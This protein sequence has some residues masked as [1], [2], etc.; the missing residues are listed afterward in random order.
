MTQLLNTL[1]VT[2]PDAALHLD[3]DTVRV[4]I[5]R[6]TRT[7]LPLLHLGAIV[8]FGPVFI[9]PAL[10]AR[11]ASDGCSVVLLSRTGRF[12]AR[13]EGPTG[14][15]VL[16]RRAQ[17][18]A[19][20]DPERAR[21][22][23]R[24]CIAGKVQNSRFVLLRSARDTN[25]VATSGVLSAA[26]TTL[27]S[28]LGPIERADSTEAL[29]GHEGDA[30]R[31]YF[32]VL[33][34]MIR[35]GQAEFRFDGRTRR[36]PRDRMNALMSFLYTLLTADCRAAAEAVGLD[37]QVGFLHALRPGRPALALDLVEE[38]RPIIADRLALTLINRRQLK[39]NDFTDRP[40]GAVMLNDQGRKTALT[41]YQER[42]RQEV[43]HRFLDQKVS[44][45]LIPHVQARLLARHL[46]GDL[47]HYPP[48]LPR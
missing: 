11:C 21:E 36:P 15:N 33:N 27:G 24:S 28:L 45:G 8:C 35:A 31:M 29:R 6:E 46:R 23:A 17:H 2:T 41:A 16:L 47:G 30:A 48:F 10:I 43:T 39:P 26:A 20:A 19:S 4:E 32:G 22:I 18:D 42:K 37:P 5:E 13:V 9:S 14:G 3:H 44:V 38:L 34:W 40:G 7:R 1:Y 12:Q 25:D